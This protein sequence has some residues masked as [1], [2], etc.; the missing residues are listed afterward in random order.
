[1]LVENLGI[2]VR[3][4]WQAGL[5]EIYIDGSFLEDRDHPNDID[6]YFHCDLLYLAS[7]QLQTYLNTLDP[8]KIWTWD[9]GRRRYDKDTHKK[10]LPMWHQY[11]VE[12]YPHYP[13]MPCGIADEFGNEQEFPAAF[14]KA[15]LRQTPNGLAMLP[16]G[17]VKILKDV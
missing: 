7:G 13:G 6:G 15:R 9:H 8:Y 10:Q 5:D 16:K 4:L 2:L 11:L 3:Q 17:I 12:L 1:M 14:R